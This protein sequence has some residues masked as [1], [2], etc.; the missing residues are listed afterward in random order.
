[1]FVAALPYYGAMLELTERPLGLFHFQV[2][3]ILDA[4]CTCYEQTGNLEKAVSLLQRIIIIKEVNSDGSMEKTKEAFFIM[5]RLAEMYMTMGNINLAKELLIKMEETAKET[6]GEQSFER[7]RVLCS[8]AGC[9][10]RNDE[11]EEAE[12]RLLQSIEVKEYIC[13]EDK[14]KLNASSIAFFNLGM[15]LYTQKRLKEAKSRFEECLKMKKEAGLASDHADV[16]ECQ[17]MLVDC[18]ESS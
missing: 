14:S 18:R 9:L 4:M 6:F 8:L 7:G 12:K 5:G 3:N 17:K 11:I 16:A 10:E 13:P 1:M 15:I 2:G